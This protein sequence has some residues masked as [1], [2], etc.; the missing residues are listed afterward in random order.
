MFKELNVEQYNPFT[1]SSKVINIDSGDQYLF[2]DFGSDWDYINKELVVT[3][4]YSENQATRIIG[5]F[6]VKPDFNIAKSVIKE[7]ED[8]DLKIAQDTLG[9]KPVYHGFEQDFVRKVGNKNFLGNGIYLE[10]IEIRKLILRSDGGV[11]LV[12][13][14]HNSNASQFPYPANYDNRFSNRREMLYEHYYDD[15]LLFSIN[16]DGTTQWSEILKKKQYSEND[17][18]YFSSFGYINTGQRIHLI[19]N[20]SVSK[21]NMLND[22]IIDTKGEYKI[23]SVLDPAEFKLNTAPRYSKQISPSEV[24]VPSINYRNEFLIIKL[25]Y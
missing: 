2:N 14:S 11:L 13:E 20:E 19:F 18:G 22:F 9:Q 21:D 25:K 23:K 4:F 8:S 6:F 7:A 1:A 10:Y 5:Y 17:Q 3:G 24:I 12:G 16:P 15:V